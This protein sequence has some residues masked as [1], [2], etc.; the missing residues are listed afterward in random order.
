MGAAE[1]DIIVIGAGS[2]GLS[3]AAGAAQMGARVAL[4]EAGKMGGDCLNVGCVPSKALIAAAQSAQRIRAAPEFGIESAA[5]TVNFMKVMAHVRDVIAGIAPHDSEARFRGLGVEVVRERARFTG[6]RTVEAGRR[7]FRAKRFVVASG[8]RPARPPIEGLAT[9]PHLTNETVWDLDELP[10]HLA[11]LGGGAVGCELAQAFRRLGARVTVVEAA[12]SLGREDPELATVVRDALRSEGVD[13]RE[14]VSVDAVSGTPGHVLLTLKTGA[15]IEASHL[16]VAAGR[17][18]NVEDMGLDAAGVETGTGG[19][20]VDSR[21]RTSNR[22]IFA[23]GDCREGP[24]FTHAANYDAG[25]V[26]RNILFRLPTRAD[27]SALPRVTFTDPELAQV[28]LTEREARE[29]H[30]RVEVQHVPFADNDRARTERRTDGL[31]KL[32]TARGRIVGCGI[33]GARAGELIGLWSLALSAGIAP[34][35]V[36]S[37]VAPYPTLGEVSKRAAGSLFTPVLFS[38]R[39]RRLVRLLLNLP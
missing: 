23:I 1:F 38:G 31:L 12:Q 37:M 25:I 33:A 30:D 32:V 17:S 22:R 2:G 11:V 27:Y 8:S 15:R 10:D 9:T 3:L 5:P 18:A 28:G 6:R 13:I 36:A 35:K 16:L 20:R 29:R 21:L 14:G 39:T 4:F 7:V 19:I 26:I 34:S 24:Q